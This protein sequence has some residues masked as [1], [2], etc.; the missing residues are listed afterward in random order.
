MRGEFIGVW[1]ETW[2]EIWLPLIDHE[3][4]PEDLFCELYRELAAALR[5]PIGD[6]AIALTVNDAILLREAFERALALAGI[7][8]ELLHVKEAFNASGATG[9]TDTLGRRAAAETALAT[10]IG[11]PARGDLLSRALL[12]IAEDPQKRAEAK[13]RA[14][15]G[16]VNG[17][18]RSREAF[19]R[20][21]PHDFAGECA[22][23]TVL[24]AVH[25]VLNDLCGDEL[26]NHYFNLLAA[27]ID[28]F[29]LR[30]DLRRPCTLCP[31]LT[32]IFASLVHDLR[33]ITSQDNHL[34][35][36][37]IGRAH[38]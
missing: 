24:E 9:F 13:E 32:G 26:S 37:K 38:V 35:A 14:L 23:V 21:R 2:R 20:V 4:V 25:P 6:A 29:S 1:S 8:V 16:I 34:D 22:L 11:D 33:A 30:Y 31:T 28:K 19:E 10:L 3:G 36:L 7:E 12:E 5:D 17:T 27:F 18:V 15:D